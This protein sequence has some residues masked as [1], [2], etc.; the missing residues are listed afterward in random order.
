MGPVKLFKLLG[1]YG[2]LQSI[3]KEKTVTATKISQIAALIVTLGCT[4]GFATWGS[5]LVD[6]NTLAFAI[7]AA[8]AQILHAVFPSIFSAP[9]STTP[10][11][12]PSGGTLAKAAAVLI[13]LGLCAFPLHAQAAWSGSDALPATPAPS[14]LP[15]NL[16][17][18]GASYNP[19]ASPSIAGTALYAHYLTGSGTGTT[20][21][22]TVVDAL[23]E[24]VKPF[25]IT[26]NV[27]A[28][29][30]EQV[31]TFDGIPIFVP[32]SAGVQWSGS[33]VGWQWNGGAMALVRVKA[34]Y[35]L[36]PSLRFLKGSVSGGS[37]YQ[38]IA[39][40]EFGWGQ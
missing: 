3:L 22:F 25:E 37:G 34:N 9:A 17:A 5:N 6:H 38:V 28:G 1:A 18:A 40:L 20:Y 26:T 11:S 23:P 33:N 32:T 29:I 36:V 10:P 27:G 12:S 19:G 16:Y 21:A 24:S 7:L 39:G 14:L 8:A 4:F 2:K 15:Q 30:A 31:A 13:V 35:Y